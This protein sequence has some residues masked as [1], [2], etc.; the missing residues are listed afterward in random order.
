[1]MSPRPSLPDRRDR[2]FSRD[3]KPSRRARV[4]GPDAIGALYREAAPRVYA[5]CLR[6]LVD[7]AEAAEVTR[8]TFV[9]IARHPGEPRT[10]C[11]AVRL[12]REKA[13]NRIAL[14]AASLRRDGGALADRG[15]VPPRLGTDRAALRAAYLFGADYRD[16]AR[17]YG[18]SVAAARE[19]FRGSLMRFVLAEQAP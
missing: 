5:L 18:V 1:M 19:R 15:R 8:D 17:S 10:P 6:I 14:S 3:P 9:D 2:F 16:L 7:P 12:A 13:V 11:E 4:T